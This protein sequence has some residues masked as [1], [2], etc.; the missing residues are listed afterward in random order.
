MREKKQMQA[1]AWTGFSRDLLTM[2]G[3]TE[4]VKMKSKRSE[5]EKCPRSE[6]TEERPQG[7]QSMR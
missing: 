4:A 7:E 3:K 1:T 2:V 6:R 5:R